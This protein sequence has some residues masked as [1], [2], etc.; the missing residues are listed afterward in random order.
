MGKVKSNEIGKQEIID[1]VTM[2]FKLPMKVSSDYEKRN[3]IIN[4]VDSYDNPEYRVWTFVICGS[5]VQ[6]IGYIKRGYSSIGYAMTV[7]YG[8][9]KPKTFYFHM[10]KDKSAIILKTTYYGLLKEYSKEYYSNR[11]T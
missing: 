10:P 2:A 4:E 6:M 3:I 7:S 8:N 9:N 1:M 5:P 11:H